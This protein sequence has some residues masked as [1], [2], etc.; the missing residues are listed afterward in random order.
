M[1]PG[2]LDL[3]VSEVERQMVIALKSFQN[4]SSGSDPG[5]KKSIL[6]ERQDHGYYLCLKDWCQTLGMCI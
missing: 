4:M 6:I 1:P 5:I 2:N 3:L